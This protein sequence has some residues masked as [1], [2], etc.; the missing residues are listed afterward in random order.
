MSVPKILADGR[1]WLALAGVTTI[2]AFQWSGIGNYLSLE[3]LKEHRETLADWVE[4]NSILAAAIYVAIYIVAVTFSF[5]GASIL[6]ITG[7]FLFGALLGAML[8]VV[9]ATIGATVIFL[10]ARTVLGENALER[11][12]ALAARVSEGIR[13]NAASYL[14]ALRFVPLV[15]FFLVNLICAFVGVRL[16]TYCVTT[17]FGIIPMTTVLSLTGAGLESLLDA[18][19]KITLSAILRPEIIAALVGLATISLLTIPLRKRLEARS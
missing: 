16:I 5:P 8:T 4:N 6:T 7:G 3:T 14:L 9:G 15:P 17:F 1:F 13:R 11:F 18:E 10:F 2:A 12:G 19:D